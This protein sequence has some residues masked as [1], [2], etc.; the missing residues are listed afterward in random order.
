MIAAL[1]PRCEVRHRRSTAN[2]P[3]SGW[4]ARATAAA[5]EAAQ[6]ADRP[7]DDEGRRRANHQQAGDTTAARRRTGTHRASRASRSDSLAE[8]FGKSVVRQIGSSTGQAMVRGILG[9]LFKSR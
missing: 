1:R 9:W 7:R 3:T 2:R 5:D 6:A 4:Q 8:A